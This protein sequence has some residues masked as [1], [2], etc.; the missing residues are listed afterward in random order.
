[1]VEHPKARPIQIRKESDKDTL[2]IL[3]IQGKHAEL[4]AGI[5]IS[6]IRAESE[7]MKVSKIANKIIKEFF[8][9]F[10]YKKSI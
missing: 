10:I 4:G 1:M 8:N 7:A 2:G 3:I 9:Y 5:F 6:D